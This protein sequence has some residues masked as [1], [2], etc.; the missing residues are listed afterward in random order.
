M[1]QD[2]VMVAIGL[3]GLLLL[4]AVFYYLENRR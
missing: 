4:T 3:M 1:N 2:P